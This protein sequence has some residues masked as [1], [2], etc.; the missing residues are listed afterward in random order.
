METEE[1]KKKS[2]IYLFLLDPLTHKDNRQLCL[3]LAFTQDYCQEEKTGD[4][5]A[6]EVT[7]FTKQI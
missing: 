1:Q 5:R 3:L 2:V 7:E 6:R 4:I